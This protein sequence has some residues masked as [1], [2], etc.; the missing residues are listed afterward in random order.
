MNINNELT[1]MNLKIAYK[2]SLEEL[3]NKIVD[4]KNVDMYLSDSGL[5]IP[6]INDTDNNFYHKY[7]F[8]NS[9]YVFL[10]NEI[11]V[12]NLSPTELEVLK[13]SLNNPCKWP[14]GIKAHIGI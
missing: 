8:L 14:S 6:R 4:F 3:L 11:H 2:R 1:L 9:E 12:E 7:S 5:L 10:R 13:K